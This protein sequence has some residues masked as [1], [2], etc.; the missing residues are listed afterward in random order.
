MRDLVDTDKA[1]RSLITKDGEKLDATAEA[2]G[3]NVCYL[4]TYQISDACILYYNVLLQNL[5]ST[6][7]AR[8]SFTTPPKPTPKPKP[9]YLK[10]KRGFSESASPNYNDMR[11]STLAIDGLWRCLCP[12][13]S[14]VD[15]ARLVRARRTIPKPSVRCL[16]VSRTAQASAAATLAPRTQRDTTPR[17]W[18]PRIGFA[19]SNPDQLQ[20]NDR[21]RIRPDTQSG[22]QFEGRDLSQKETSIL[23]EWLRSA[24]RRGATDRVER[25]VQELVKER[26]EQPN[27]RLYGALILVNTNPKDGAAWRVAALLQQME[28]EGVDID[29]GICHDVLKV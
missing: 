28:E 21:L 17:V 11:T 22:D 1:I 13:V 27:G 10:P 7:W 15:T 29:V 24:A 20:R 26:G 14:L 23:Y 3:Q 25:I 4:R 16:H 9:T 8:D 12:S 18:R 6:H 2:S 19:N 5:T